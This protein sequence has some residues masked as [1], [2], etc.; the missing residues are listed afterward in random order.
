MKRTNSYALPAASVNWFR[1]ESSSCRPTQKPRSRT[2]KGIRPLGAAR[3][4]QEPI[5][6]DH[7]PKKKDRK[8]FVQTEDKDL[9]IFLIQEHKDVDALCV[10]CREKFKMG[11]YSVEWPP[12]T[13]RPPLPPIANAIE[14]S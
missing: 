6:K 4:R 10:E 9:R 11:G 5:F 3:Q 7:I 12:G 2:F 8:I 1:Y 13:F 14:W